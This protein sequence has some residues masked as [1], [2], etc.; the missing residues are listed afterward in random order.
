MKDFLVVLRLVSQ[1]EFSAQQAANDFIKKNIKIN[2]F[3]FFTCERLC[4]W[5]LF[6]IQ[7][8]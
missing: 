4:Q 7:N 1:R 3:V 2:I 5:I 6:V 8:G